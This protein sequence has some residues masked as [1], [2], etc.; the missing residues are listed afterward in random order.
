MRG[1]VTAIRL[2]SGPSRRESARGGASRRESAAGRL[3]PLRVG[4]GTGRPRN[5]RPRRR[6]GA[7]PRKR[8]C[9]RAARL[10]DPRPAT[11]KTVP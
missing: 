11:T 7:F 2:R 1:E 6:R 3:P 8:L 10:R 9:V 4:A 5:H